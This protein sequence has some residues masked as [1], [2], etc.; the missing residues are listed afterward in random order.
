MRLN[1]RRTLDALLPGMATIYI[2]SHRGNGLAAIQALQTTQPDGPLSMI[3]E[4]NSTEER[5]S[6]RPGRPR[7]S[8]SLLRR[9]TPQPP[10]A[11]FTLC[12]ESKK[13][14]LRSNRIVLSANEFGLMTVLL[15]SHGRV[16]PRKDLL[17]LVWGRVRTIR[18]IG[19]TLH[20]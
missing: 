12:P 15:R 13:I 18:G 19:F 1:Q 17:L 11:T 6:C 20:E 16:V 5:I 4:L 10:T 3:G 7:P 14:N 9:F 8:R 2:G